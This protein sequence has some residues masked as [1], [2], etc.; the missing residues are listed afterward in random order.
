[1]KNWIKILL[2]LLVL[3]FLASQVSFAGIFD[4]G[5]WEF[6]I[7]YSKWSL[8]LVRGLIEDKVGEQMEEEF[9]E[10]IEEDHPE[11]G[12]GIYRQDISFDSTGNNY[13]FE[14]R[15]YPSGK[16]G[17]FS[18]GLSIEKTRME[19]ELEGNVRDD[20]SNGSYMDAV[21][22]GTVI[23]EPLSVNLSL[24]WDIKPSWKIR[25]YF[26]YGF[27]ISPVK[28]NTS[29]SYTGRFYN[30]DKDEFEDESD[31]EEKDLKDVEDFMKFIPIIQFSF[32]LKGELAE[33]LYILVDAGLWTGFLLR[34]GVTYRF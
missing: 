19:L 12:A 4:K 34:A 23:L 31:S 15:F 16:T 1:M 33:N 2:Y 17:S 9:Q 29:L 27:G 18:L 6:N 32:G 3:S 7:H 8:N 22:N 5:K 28:G 26:T 11:L 13:G 24:S 21:A 25:P 30:A 14:I 20:F 10:N